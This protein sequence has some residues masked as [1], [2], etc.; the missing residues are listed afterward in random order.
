MGVGDQEN[1]VPL[2]RWAGLGI[3]MGNAAPAVKE[4]ADWIAPPLK[5]DGAAVAIERFILKR[6]SP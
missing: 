5:E 1:D 2:V 6:G 4:A 3:A